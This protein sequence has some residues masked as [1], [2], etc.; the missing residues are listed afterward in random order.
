MRRNQLPD[1]RHFAITWSI[2]D[3]FGGM[4]DALLR[5]SAAFLRVG[6]V[7]VD[8]LTF[9]ARPDTPEVELALRRRGD[10]PTGVR[11]TNL[12]DWLRTHQLPGG[13]LRLEPDEFTPLTEADA[14]ETRRRGELVTSRSRL[15][16]NGETLQTDHYRA[17]GSLLLSD[18]SDVR[19]RGVS[20][21]RSIV[22]CDGE[23]R[24]VRSWR[25]RWSL[26]RAW[27]DALTRGEP[28]FMIVDSKSIARF[29]LTYRRANVIT[30][31]VVHASHRS[32]ASDDH[33]I[34]R[35]R[36]DVL[37]QVSD[38]DV[39]AV[40]SDRQRT[41][42]QRIVG[43]QHHLVTIPNVR[44]RPEPGAR[45]ARSGLRRDPARGIVLAALTRRKRVSHA[46]AAVQAA[47]ART[48]AHL[49]LVVYGDGESRPALERRIADPT[50][51]ELHGFEPDA[52]RHLLDASFLLLTSHSEGF[53]LVL[54]EAMAAGCLPI[55]Y[56]VPYGPA[57]LIRD[58]RNGFLV[59]A[60][61]V[62]TLA[63]AIVRLQRMPPRRVARMRASAV[64]SARRFDEQ[65]VTRI[66]ARELRRGAARRE[67][68]RTGR[69][70]AARSVAARLPLPRPVRSIGVDIVHGVNRVLRVLRRA[71]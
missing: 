65:R 63:D 52:R 21:G 48:S 3:E 70:G 8:V 59:P 50:V 49:H 31:H 55:A 51:V 62:D 9:D 20:G 41:D 12:Y 60:G 16:A 64:R 46:I 54:V 18:R 56:D 66:W 14:T 36:R 40:L 7:E 17:D 71:G 67:L 19:R 15:G 45:E 35:S 39:V 28:S 29:M 58:G 37:T 24:P 57:D 13:S 47:D 5:R 61:D 23:G 42:L 1:G 22:L 30:A 10:L 11:I 25:R 33:P 26:Y 4:T 38:F 53:P 6:G 69:F 32:A 27:L 43:R 34:R 2:P 68:R 44:P